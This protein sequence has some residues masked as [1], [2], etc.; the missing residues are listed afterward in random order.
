MR[1]FYRKRLNE[2]VAAI[3]NKQSVRISSQYADKDIRRERLIVLRGLLGKSQVEF[4]EDL[5]IA[6]TRLQDMERGR[7]SVGMTQLKLAEILYKSFLRKKADAKRRRLKEL[8]AILQ[9]PDNPVLRAK[10]VSMH[11]RGISQDEIARQLALR[12]EVIEYW[13]SSVV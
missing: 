3:L 6:S 9:I 8:A 1:Q 11:V 10:A 13:I 12:P 7:R 5:G 2:Q 4:A